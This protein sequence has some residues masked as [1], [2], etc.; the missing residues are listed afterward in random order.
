MGNFSSSSVHFASIC[1]LN[2]K[3]GGGTKKK[4]KNGKQTLWNFVGTATNGHNFS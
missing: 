4:K 3:K 2:L 1:N